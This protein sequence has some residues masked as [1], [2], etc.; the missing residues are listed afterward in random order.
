MSDSSEVCQ[1]IFRHVLLLLA[2]LLLLRVQS[3]SVTFFIKK[4][5][6]YTFFIVVCQIDFDSVSWNTLTILIH[7]HCGCANSN[8]FCYFFS[9]SISSQLQQSFSNIFRIHFLTFHS[10]RIADR[11]AFFLSCK[12]NYK[13]GNNYYQDKNFGNEFHGFLKKHSCI[14]NGFMIEYQI[15]KGNCFPRLSIT[16]DFLQP[17][18]WR[19]RE[20][21]CLGRAE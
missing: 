12:H 1:Y 13:S 6:L 18:L 16:S 3:L 5:F 4:N 7:A 2:I 19:L 15:S 14:S 9:W 20:F 10:P 17:S 21:R 8:G 11:T